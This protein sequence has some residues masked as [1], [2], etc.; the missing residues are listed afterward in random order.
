MSFTCTLTNNAFNS[1]VQHVTYPTTGGTDYY[2]ANDTFSVTQGEDV[3]FYC[4]AGPTNTI[5]L[6]GT[7]VA[8]TTNYTWTPDADFEVTFESSIG[9]YGKLYIVRTSQPVVTPRVTITYNGNTIQTISSD[10]TITLPTNGKVMATDIVVSGTDVYSTEIGYNGDTVATGTG[11][12]TKTLQCANKVMASDVEVDVVIETPVLID[13]YIT[14]SSR[15]PFGL[16]TMEEEAG[17]DGTIEYSID[18]VNWS[19]WD[20]ETPL[21]SSQSGTTKYLYIRGSNNTYIARDYN[22]WVILDGKDVS[23]SGYISKLLNYNMDSV[24]LGREA[25]AYL[26]TENDYIVDASGLI[27]NGNMTSSSEDC[28]EEMFSFSTLE[29]PPILPS[30]TLSFGCYTYM[31]AGC[32]SL[33]TAPELPATTLPGRCYEGMFSGC[34]SLTTA[35]VLPATTLAFYCY[36]DMFVDCI[37]LTS[38]PTLPATTLANYCYDSMFYN[39]TSITSMPALP[40]TTLTNYCYYR[41][42]SGCTNIKL[43]TSRTGAYQTAYRIPKS[44]TGTTG[45][46]SLQDM[47]YDTG[48]SFKGTPTI[49][50]TYYTS[51][52]VI[53]PTGTGGGGN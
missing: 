37:S 22:S 30:T 31:F 53:S 11:T 19:V 33:T 25:L 48:G 17:W 8:S 6:D 52:T 46:N 7:V 51:N 35:P 13:N 20:G 27:L 23:V 18:T 4:N 38:A 26:F 14:F 16:I 5:Y 21:D 28:Y 41:M 12:F 32:E 40:A 34:R 36:A 9:T 47:F 1:I 42:F 3:R 2:T 45:T 50:T 29:K 44:G 10:D 49:N 15:W 43:S 39:C 24:D